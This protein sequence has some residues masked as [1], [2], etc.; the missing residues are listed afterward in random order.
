VT[1]Q[2]DRVER[3]A[4]RVLARSS[5]TVRAYRDRARR[6]RNDP[7]RYARE[8]LGREL[9]PQQETI[10]RLSLTPPYRVLV[11]SANT[12][13][14]TFAGAC[15]ASW[16]FDTFD[17]SITLITATTWPQVRDL[18]FRELRAVR[19]SWGFAP[20]DT[21]LESSPHHFVHGL[22]ANKPDAFQG[23]HAE[24][25]CVI[26][27]EAT[28]IDRA[29]WLRAQTMFGGHE[30]HSWLCF[31]NPNDPSSYAYEAE[32]SNLWHVVRLNALEHPNIAAELSGRPP[33]IPSAV[34]LATVRARIAAEC[35]EVSE[36]DFDAVT[37]FTFDGVRYRPKT[38]EFEAQV[39]GRWPLSASASLFSPALVAQC[40]SRPL[41]LD[42]VWPVAL[43]CDVSRFGDD[44]TAIVGR[45]GPCAVHAETHSRRDS[46]GIADRLIELT[47]RIAGTMDT[48]TAQQVPI[49]IDGTGGY[50]G[51][52]VD[53]LRD[54]G[55]F[56]ANEILMS[57]ESPD[58]RILRMRSYLWFRLAELAQAGL[59]DLSRLNGS[60]A[61]DLRAD[62]TAPRYRVDEM[63]RKVL[64]PKHQIKS[65]LGRSPDVAD[66][67][68]LAYYG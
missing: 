52:V 25:L 23:R 14:K 59:L 65:R 12:Q 41:D 34:R 2:L 38:P 42:P 67:L 13:G 19:P 68:G 61:N 15:Y 32:E 7:A 22:T 16:F 50:G 54:R 64:E 39:L 29:F 18:M 31:Y 4:A 66:A 27:D 48:R 58:P 3:L 63:G 45:K 28:G 26:F 24:N 17:P 20:K 47:F 11:P 40:L 21:R 51:G 44:R 33:P 35:T 53:R 9:T 1:A 60:A 6:Y 5:D 46:T 57:Q 36:S 55:W 49:W 56:G 62:L 8:V 37:D 10:F 43:G 30:G